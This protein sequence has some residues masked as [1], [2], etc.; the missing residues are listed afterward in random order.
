MNGGRQHFWPQCQTRQAP[1]MPRLG[2]PEAGELRGAPIL[3][4]GG[5]CMCAS[6][7][8]AGEGLGQRNP[9]PFPGVHHE[10]CE[11]LPLPRS[12]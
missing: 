12:L 4:A 2:V 10:A 6:K 7:R 5:G 8:T 9:S 11:Q 3:I 1:P